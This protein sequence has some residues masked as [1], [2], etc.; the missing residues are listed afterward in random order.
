MEL[1]LTERFA[2][3]GLNGKGSNHRNL[4][5]LYVLKAI[6]VAFYLE[7]H[8][9]AANATW[10]F[11][12]DGIM[13]ATK[14]SRMK[15]IENQIITRLTEKQLIKTVK[16]LLGCDLY[17][18]NNIKL[19]DYVS[20]SKEY[21]HQI[22]YLRAEFLEDGPVSE[23]GIILI[24]LLK[25][26]LCMDEVFSL[27][28]QKKIQ[29]KIS[30]ISKNSALARKLFTIDMQSTGGSIATGF[31]CMKSRFAST[32][33]GKGLNFIFPAIE[34]KQSIF[35]DTEEYF[36]NTEQRLQCVI[37]RVTSQGHSCEVLHKGTVPIV[38]ID[39]VKYELVPEAIVVKFPIHGVRLRRCD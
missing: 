18:D 1:S 31:L 8:Y 38:K 11:D 39:N 15:E 20:D 28:E 3:I 5:K 25:N 24:W 12:E 17:Y 13:K 34:R 22:D 19:K 26:A 6:A 27:S 29:S 36:S 7:D 23:E 16:N 4:A 14:K 30:E 9:D 33:I 10:D 37:N 2:L 35:I 21:E 32:P